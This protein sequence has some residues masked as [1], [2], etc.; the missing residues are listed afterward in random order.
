METAVLPLALYR[1]EIWSLTLS[2]ERNWMEL[3]DLRLLRREDVIP[4][5]LVE[6]FTDVSEY[7]AV[8]F[9]AEVC[10]ARNWSGR[11]QGRRGEKNP[12]QSSRSSE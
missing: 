3:L 8:T 7:A 9:S 10:R 6:K 4:C 5:S 2:E 11:L 12:V 1:R